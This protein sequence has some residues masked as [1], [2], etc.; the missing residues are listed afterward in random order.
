LGE[1]ENRE[2][3]RKEGRAKGKGSRRGRKEKYRGINQIIG[4]N[5]DIAPRGQRG[6]DDLSKVLKVERG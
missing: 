4:P 3:E 1:G 6:E 5:H 2:E